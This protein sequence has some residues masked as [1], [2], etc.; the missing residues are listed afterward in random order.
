MEGD[1][2]AKNCAPFPTAV[3]PTESAHSKGLPENPLKQLPGVA[4]RLPTAVVATI[5]LHPLF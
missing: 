5:Y 1:F 3:R 2:N 4:A